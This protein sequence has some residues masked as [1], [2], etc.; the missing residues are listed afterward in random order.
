MGKLTYNSALTLHLDD[1]LLAHL[2]AAIGTRLQHGQG[3]YFSWV[4]RPPGGTGRTTIWLH[5]Q[6]PLSYKYVGSHRPPLNP[7]WV[8]ALLLTANAPT[9]LEIIPEPQGA[10][11]KVV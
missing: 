5:P 6:I 3:C 2:E 7:H 11:Q 8:H 1:R 9:G 10:S 4:D